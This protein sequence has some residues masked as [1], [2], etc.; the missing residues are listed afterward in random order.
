MSGIDW[1]YLFLYLFVY[2][3]LFMVAACA[4]VI[5]VIAPMCTLAIRLSTPIWKKLEKMV[6]Y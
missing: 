5:L 4:Y 1:F 6:D 2:F 3:P